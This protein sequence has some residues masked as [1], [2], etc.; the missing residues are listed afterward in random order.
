MNLSPLVGMAGSV[1]MRNYSA[2]EQMVAGDR[3][4]RRNRLSGLC[5]ADIFFRDNAD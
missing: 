1:R 4:A 3:Q 2:N 5:R